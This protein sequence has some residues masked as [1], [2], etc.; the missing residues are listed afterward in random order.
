M[1]ILSN[2]TKRDKLL[3]GTTPAKTSRT[4]FKEFSFDFKMSLQLF[5]QARRTKQFSAN[6]IF[7]PVQ[8]RFWKIS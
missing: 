1:A 3:G 6:H 8:N 2:I 5:G 4:L 7:S